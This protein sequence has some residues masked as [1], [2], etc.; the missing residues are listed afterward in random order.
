MRIILKGHVSPETAYLV[1]DYPYGFRLRC[2]IRYWL[3][4]KPRLGFRLMTQTLN[5]KNN[6]WNNAKAATYAKF[7]AALYLNDEGHVRVSV[8]TEYCNGAEAKAWSDQWRHTIENKAALATLDAW[9]AG[10]VAYDA[11]RKPGDP[12]R[13]GLPEARAA[14]VAAKLVEPG[15]FRVADVAAGVGPDGDYP[16]KDGD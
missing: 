7:G 12:L 13:V 1:E 5:P 6:R 10:K 11:N 15:N 2:K 14:M 4:W 3:E 8:L 16:A 9:V